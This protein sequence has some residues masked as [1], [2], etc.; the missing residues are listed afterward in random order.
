ME[1]ATKFVINYLLI[2]DKIIV[3]NIKINKPSLYQVHKEISH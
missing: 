3:I 1:E 2:V